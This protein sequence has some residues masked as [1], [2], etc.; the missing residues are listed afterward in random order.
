MNLATTLLRK[1]RPLSPA[2][3]A[4]IQEYRGA[5]KPAISRACTV[6]DAWLDAVLIEREAGRLAN[7]ASVYRWELARLAQ[8]L[9]AM[10]PP[11][12]VVRLHDRLQ[13]AVFDTSR[14]CQ[15]LANGHRFYNSDAVCDGQ[16]LLIDAVDRVDRL[17]QD[18]DTLLA[19]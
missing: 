16:A 1:L 5:V 6:R 9:D 7:A 13:S 10:E 12:R 15:S 8:T 4:Q 14:A 19:D 17:A 2:D 11:R 18:L 3:R